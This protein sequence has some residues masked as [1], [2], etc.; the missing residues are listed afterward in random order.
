VQ[1]RQGIRNDWLSWIEQFFFFDGDNRLDG[2]NSNP[3]HTGYRNARNSEWFHMLKEDVAS[4]VDPAFAKE[5][6]KPMLRG[7]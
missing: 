6:M 3:L 2:H 4:I 5:Q 1:P 7:W